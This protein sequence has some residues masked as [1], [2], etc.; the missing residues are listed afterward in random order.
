MLCLTHAA[1]NPSLAQKIAIAVVDDDEAVREAVT[2]LIRSLG[3][4]AS[5]FER[6]DDFLKSSS[7]GDICCLIVDMQMPRMTG[8]AL[9]HQ[10]VATG[11]PIP[12]I[13]I[14]AYPDEKMRARAL[15]DGVICYLSKPFKEDDLLAGIQAALDQ[16][17]LRG[18]ERRG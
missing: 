17:S 15:Q 18:T 5:A 14:T 8:I 1:W 7:R 16:R 12:T 10:L 2:S 6:P 3:Y 11:D 9:Y 4:N 13:L